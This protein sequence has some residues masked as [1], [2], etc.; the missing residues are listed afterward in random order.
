M[1]LD[2]E[3]LDK[4]GAWLGSGDCDRRCRGL[5]FAYFLCRWITSRH[6]PGKD[7]VPSNSTLTRIRVSGGSGKSLL[8]YLLFTFFTLSFNERRSLQHRR[9]FS[10]SQERPS[11]FAVQSESVVRARL[12]A[13]HHIEDCLTSS[14]WSAGQRVERGVR[15]CVVTVSVSAGAASAGLSLGV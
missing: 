1:Q 9:S 11:A 10:S 6:S 15:Y 3:K 14:S 8:L 4:G 12:C 7:G 5:P 13:S 2:G